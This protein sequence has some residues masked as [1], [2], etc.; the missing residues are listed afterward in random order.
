MKN[1]PDVAYA[2]L[3][4]AASVPV[5]SGLTVASLAPLMGKEVILDGICSV[6][7]VEPNDAVNDYYSVAQR[8]ANRRHQQQIKDAGLPAL[9]RDNVPVEIAA[10]IGS[11][12]EAPGAFTCG[13][14]GIG[15]FRTEMLYMDR[16]SAPDE[17]EQFEA[18]QQVLLSAQGKPVIFR[19]MDIGGDKQIPYLNIPGKKTRSSAIV[20]FVFIPNLPISSAPNCA[21][22]YAQAPAAM[23]C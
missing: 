17:Q 5:L 8:L 9:T 22:S 19:T 11:A 2:D 16:D 15:L 20:P 1:R 6:L 7:V 23:R 14:Q 18:Y 10:N 4:R 21:R 12:L 3:A 13:A